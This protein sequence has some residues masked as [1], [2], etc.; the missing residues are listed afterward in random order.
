MSDD[1]MRT[2]LDAVESGNMS[3]RAAGELLDKL[4]A[5][6]PAEPEQPAE[7]AEQ[8]APATRAPSLTTAPRNQDEADAEARHMLE[9]MKRSLPDRFAA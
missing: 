9:A 5:S 6:A 8:Q 3:A 1:T 2:I 7:A 4:G